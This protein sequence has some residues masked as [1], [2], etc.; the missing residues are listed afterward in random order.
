MSALL[1]Q[2][3]NAATLQSKPGDERVKTKEL[4]PTEVVFKVLAIL[5]NLLLFLTFQSP[6]VISFKILFYFSV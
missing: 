3:H 2:F 4:T 6:R 5:S 1:A